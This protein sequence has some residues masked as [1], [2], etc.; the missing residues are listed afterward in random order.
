[1]IPEKI[2]IIVGLFDRKCDYYVG[3]TLGKCPSQIRASGPPRIIFSSLGL[4]SDADRNLI[5][6]WKRNETFD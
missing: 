1:M 4:F 2:P 6:F 3:Q 5:G